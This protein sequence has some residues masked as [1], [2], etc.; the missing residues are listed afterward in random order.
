M[1]MGGGANNGKGMTDSTVLLLI[2][3]M[4]VKVR[5]ARM[6]SQQVSIS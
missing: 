3:F 1:R 4:T 6:I 5:M 2:V